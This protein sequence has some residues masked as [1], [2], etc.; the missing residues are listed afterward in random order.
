MSDRLN[1]IS[2][3]EIRCRTSWTSKFCKMR[4]EVMVYLRTAQGFSWNPE[5]SLNQHARRTSPSFIASFRIKSVRSAFIRASNRYSIDSE[6]LGEF[7]GKLEKQ[8][9][10]WAPK[11]YDSER[12]T[13]SAKSLSR[14]D[15]EALL[16]GILYRTES[17][18]CS[19]Y[20][21]GDYN[22]SNR[23]ASRRNAQAQDRG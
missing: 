18:V 19:P 12:S 16:A 9:I 13:M 20:L 6:P 10:A 15:L 14:A 1:P 8:V 21:L 7:A 23:S 2:G 4:V 11:R 3:C 5:Q 17:Q 22:H